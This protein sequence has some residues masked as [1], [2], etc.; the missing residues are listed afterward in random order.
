[1][2]DQRIRSMLAVLAALWGSVSICAAQPPDDI[3]SWRFPKAAD[4]IFPKATD[5]RFP[6][7][8]D[9]AGK[10]TDLQVHESA[11]EIRIEMSADVLFEFD[12]ATLTEKAQDSLQQAASIIRDKAKGRV[13]IDGHTDGK[14]EERYNLRLSERRANAVKTWFIQKAGLPS[15]RFATHGYGKQRPVASNTKPD[16]SDDPEGR[17]KNRRVEIVFGK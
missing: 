14:G 3:S 12:K 9:L 6:L 15:A 13:R 5:L 7:P 8:K 11:S 16:G 4:L 2:K 1:M 17:Q 10:T